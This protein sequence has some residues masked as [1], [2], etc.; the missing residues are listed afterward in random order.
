MDIAHVG[1]FVE[2][3]GGIYA[4][5][6]SKGSVL[7]VTPRFKK[8]FGLTKLSGAPFKDSDLAEDDAGIFNME[9]LLDMGAGLKDFADM[10]IR[11]RGQSYHLQYTASRFGGI[12]GGALV[13]VTDITDRL[14]EDERNRKELSD[15]MLLQ[16]VA[17]GR[18]KKMDELR[19]KIEE[20]TRQL[21]ELGIS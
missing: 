7:A 21:N 13:N 10:T 6:N 2:S 17:F 15:L 5:V 16:K 11:W 9:I 1:F 12:F 14:R 4:F 3:L 19:L 18:E 8:I 20:L